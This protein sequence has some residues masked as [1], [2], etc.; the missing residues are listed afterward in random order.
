MGLGR[1]ATAVVGVLASLG[2]SA[3]LWVATGSPVFFL[4][5]PFVPVL[6]GRG[7]DRSGA[8]SPRRSCPQCDFETTRTGFEYC[9]HD[10]RR[11]VVDR[12]SGR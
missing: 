6:F 9:P 1:V 7:R 3:G 2:L 12:R 11:L 10:G 8:A 5:V 4:F